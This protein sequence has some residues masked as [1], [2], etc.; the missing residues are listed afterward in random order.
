ML[1]KY[2]ILPCCNT[3]S[4]YQTWCK[5]GDEQTEYN[6]NI[7]EINVEYVY[8][9]IYIYIYIYTHTHTRHK[10]ISNSVYKFMTNIINRVY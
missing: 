8:I 7:T 5:H 9:Y 6:W 3:D 2:L 10:T 1:C 4:V